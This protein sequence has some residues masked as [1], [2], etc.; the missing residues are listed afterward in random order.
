[1][2]PRSPH[3]VICGNDL[4]DALSPAVRDRFRLETVALNPNQVMHEAGAFAEYVF[5]PTASFR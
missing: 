4:L 5:F 3:D 2:S 1:M